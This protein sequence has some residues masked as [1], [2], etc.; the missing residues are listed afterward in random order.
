MCCGRNSRRGFT[1]L[2]VMIATIIVGMVAISIY[3]FVQL[4]LTAIR[5]S[6]AQAASEIAVQGLVAIL[7]AQLNDLPAARQGVLAGQAHKFNDVPRD[8]MSWI[9][10]AGNGLLTKNAIG[11]YKVTLLLKRPERSAQLQLGAWRVRAD[12]TDKEGDWVPLINNVSGLEIRYFDLRM[13]GWLEKWTDLRARPSLVRVRL[14]RANAT[15]PYEVVL[16]LPASRLPA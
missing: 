1:L 13:N 5:L 9:C 6:S 7:Q 15:E 16:T 12:G 10:S 14:W 4:N 2:E 11:D 8:E 3:R